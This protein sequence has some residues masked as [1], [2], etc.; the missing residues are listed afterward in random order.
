MSTIPTIPIGNLT[1][2]KKEDVL[3]SEISCSNTYEISSSLPE[4]YQT[5]EDNPYQIYYDNF[6]SPAIQQQYE[7]TLDLS[8]LDSL[9]ISKEVYLDSYSEIIDLYCRSGTGSVYF[10]DTAL[11]G[12]NAGFGQLSGLDLYKNMNY[13]EMLDI[14][15]LKESIVNNI[16]SNPCFLMDINNINAPINPLKLEMLKGNFRLLCRSLILFTKLQNLFVSSV[17]DNTEFYGSG[18]YKD[19][20]FVDYCFE[21]FIN[22]IDSLIPKYRKNIY[23]FMNEELK[24][25]LDSG[26]EIYDPIT[27]EKLKFSTP[28]TDDNMM[29]NMKKYAQVLFKNEFIFLAQKANLFFSQQGTDSGFSFST[30]PSSNFGVKLLSAK[31]FFLESIPVFGLGTTFGV[32][33]QG[34]GPFD[35]SYTTYKVYNSFKIPSSIKFHL[36]V[37]GTRTENG[38]DLSLSLV[39]YYTDVVDKVTITKVTKSYRSEERDNESLLRF[40]KSKLTDLKQLLLED[41]NFLLFSNYLFP[42]NKILN[43]ASIVHVNLMLK[44]YQSTYN[45]LDGSI[46]TISNIHDIV[47]GNEDKL[48][49]ET[50]DS[51]NANAAQ[52]NI[53]LGINLEI[54]KAIATFPISI[55]KALEETYDPNIFIASKIRA[56]AESLGAP[57]LPIIPYSLGLLPALTIPP[58]VGVGPP[59]IPPWGYIYWGVDAAEIILEYAKNGVQTGNVQPLFQP[60]SKNP[61]KPDC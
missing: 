2:Y 17:F 27:N 33:D 7:T 51:T 38:Y 6:I 15:E 18:D 30:A 12:S 14:Q 24:T 45:I 19:S 50:P 10:R 3:F 16:T 53:I 29:E 41:N 26:T 34:Y 52:D 54:A 21:I 46:A 37:E 43:I 5:T 9:S 23:A 49:C 35:K 39:H 57:K 28:V 44:T 36:Y 22:K 8:I 60:I 20:T 4:D 25:K 58:P 59:L 61:T 11:T 32:Y 48:D 47:L 55:L 40:A 31:E 42:L 1:Y 13:H 56:A